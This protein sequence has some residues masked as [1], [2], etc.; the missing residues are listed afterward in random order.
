DVVVEDEL[1]SSLRMAAAE[2]G[3]DPLAARRAD[4]VG[5]RLSERAEEQLDDPLVEARSAAD[6]DAG[7]RVEEGSLGR[8]D[9]H[10]TKLTLVLR[11]RVL[12]RD[13]LRHPVAV[14]TR[15]A[16]RAVDRGRRLLCAAGEVE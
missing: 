14:R 10:R 13:C 4:T 11:D 5:D 2:D 9:T 12:R 3:I 6:R 7:S 15:V 8:D 1:I 16:Q